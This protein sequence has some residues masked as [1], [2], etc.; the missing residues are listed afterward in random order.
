M[1]CNWLAY[2]A[3]LEVP[4]VLAQEYRASPYKHGAGAP[5]CEGRLSAIVQAQRQSGIFDSRWKTSAYP[6]F[7][8][9]GGGL[10]SFSASMIW[11]NFLIGS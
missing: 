7:G 3:P 1:E 4:H 10:F 5:H 2:R 8:S 9:P 6:S 11:S